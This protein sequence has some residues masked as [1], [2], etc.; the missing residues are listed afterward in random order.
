M[1]DQDD[2]QNNLVLM[3]VFGL[4]TLAL[5]LV[6]ALVIRQVNGRHKPVVPVEPVAAVAASAQVGSNT[7][8]EAIVVE[9]IYFELGGGSMPADGSAVIARV[10]DVLKTK[11]A[12]KI[13]VS[14]F[15]DASGNVALNAELAKQRAFA[16]RDALAAAGVKADQVVLDKPQQM[17]GG[18]DANEARRVELTLR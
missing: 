15:H 11:P 14:G 2:G 13:L 9:K 10:V 8:I 1:S 6:I 5:G 17:M 4:I 12:A 18:G 16:V 7:T 3:V